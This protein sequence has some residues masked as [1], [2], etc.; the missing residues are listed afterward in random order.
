M[1]HPALSR[2]ESGLA[3]ARAA[4]LQGELEAM[5][6]RLVQVLDALA[7]V[8][9]A[10]FLPKQERAAQP[11]DEPQV[12]AL[13][14]QLLAAFKTA[15]CHVF[16]YAGTLLGLQRDARLLAD[17]KDAD[18]G[19]WL[20]DYSLAGRLLLQWG[21]QRA[22][23]VPPFANM[24]TYVDPRNG[25]SVDLFG[26]RRDPVRERVEGG[27]WL[28][29][30]P[31][32]HQR[33]LLLPWFDLVAQ[34]SPAGA[35]WWPE[36]ADRV[37]AALYG[38]DWRVPQPEWDSL[39]SNLSLHEINLNWRCWALKNLCQSWLGGDLGRTRRLLAQITGRAGEDPQLRG[40]REALE[41]AGA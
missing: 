27:A 30:K 25:T 7:E 5:H 12:R 14:W 3:G 20:E 11:W 10:G 8:T 6:A 4:L 29:G 18:L 9:R 33:L 22:T 24:S 32:S 26:L 23:D 38:P 15:D 13:V 41:G 19:V 39:V 21:L 1:T 34:E 16:P 31:P 40:W 17:D 36:Q 2:I 35:V 37:L 28:Y